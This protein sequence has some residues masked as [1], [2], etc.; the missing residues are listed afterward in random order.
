LGKV[1]LEQLIPCSRVFAKLI[2]PQL[3]RHPSLPPTCGLK[4]LYC[5]WITLEVELRET[6][7]KIYIEHNLT[8]KLSLLPLKIRNTS[9]RK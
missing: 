4:V 6:E 5:V 1:R 8:R 3:L 9:R 7:L 2:V